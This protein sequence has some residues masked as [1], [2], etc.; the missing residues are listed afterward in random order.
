MIKISIF[1]RFAFI[2]IF[3]IL[4]AI[5]RQWILS[6]HFTLNK[7]FLFVSASET[8]QYLVDDPIII[9][10]EIHAKEDESVKL[11]YRMQDHQDN[12]EEKKVI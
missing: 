8:I 1:T 5:K 11:L 2:F 7:N 10:R 9:V 3:L 12:L 6:F 4:K